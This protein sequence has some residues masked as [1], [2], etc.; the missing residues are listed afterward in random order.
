MTKIWTASLQLSN[1]SIRATF[2]PARFQAGMGTKQSMSRN[3]ACTWPGLDPANICSHKAFHKYLP[4]FGPVCFS[5]LDHLNLTAEQRG[6]AAD[7]LG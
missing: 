5:C 2:V 4:D 1:S 7:L 3:S 6:S